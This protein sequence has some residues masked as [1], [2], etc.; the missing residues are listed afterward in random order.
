MKNADHLE[1]AYLYCKQIIQQHSKSFYYAFSQLP[2]EKAN[3]VY[4]IYAFCRLADDG[5]DEV[6][7]RELQL[8]N[9]NRLEKELRLFEKGKELDHPLWLAL[10]DVFTRYNMD[11]SPFYDQLKGQAMDVYFSTLET[12]EQVEKYSYYVAGSVGLMLL[13]IIAS[14]STREL[15][16]EAISLGIAMQI[17]NILRDVGEDYQ[18]NQKI[19]LPRQ[20]MHGIGYTEDKLALGV[21]NEEFISIWERMANRAENLYEIFLDHVHHFDDDSKVPLVLSA[22]VY[23]GILASVRNNDYDCFGKRNAI[24]N[25]DMQKIYST[26]K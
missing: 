22:K 13:P 8:E 2:E 10:R 20:E 5:V 4:A 3:A 23:R 16:D 11:I 19:Y 26:I 6:T 21:I 15:S 9:L 1:E 14:T 18:A 24:S 7:S 12:M 17:T 25:E